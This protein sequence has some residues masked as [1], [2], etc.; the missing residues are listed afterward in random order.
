MLLDEKMCYSTSEFSL[1]GLWFSFVCV[2]H[3][4]LP[5]KSKNE[6]N[7]LRLGRNCLAFSK[8]HLHKS[9]IISIGSSIRS[10]NNNSTCIH[11]S[12]KCTMFFFVCQYNFIKV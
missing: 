12:H 3:H 9:D 1:S 7:I 11:V 8:I 10:N 5:K 4:W 2:G 6:P